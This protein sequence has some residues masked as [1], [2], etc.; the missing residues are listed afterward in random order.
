M[1][2]A[3]I[4]LGVVAG[5]L[6]KCLCGSDA[7]AYRH[8]S[9]SLDGAMQ[10][11]APRLKVESLHALQQAESFINAIAIEPGHLLTDE[12]HDAV[13]HI[14][15]E[16]IVGRENCNIHSRELLF[17]L[18][19]RHSGLDTKPLCLIASGHDTAVVV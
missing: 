11:F 16:L 2:I 14:E 12:R 6:G 15:V 4:V 18:E 7:Y 9:A 19:V 17:H 10:L 8:G 5:H 1:I 3:R 13:G